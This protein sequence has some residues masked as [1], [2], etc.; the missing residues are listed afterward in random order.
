MDGFKPLGCAKV[1]MATYRPDT[2]D[3]ALMRYGQLDRKIEVPLPNGHPRLEILGIHAGPMN[4]HGEIDY[5]AI[6]KVRSCQPGERVNSLLPN[7]DMLLALG[8]VQRG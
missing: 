3:R 6:V 5:E 8:W 2:V 1:I 4:K 7:I